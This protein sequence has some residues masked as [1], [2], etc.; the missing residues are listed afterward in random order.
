MV[1]VQADVPGM[2][3]RGVVD[4]VK[5]SYRPDI[6]GLRA[7]SILLV[8]VF[9]AG[10]SG[11]S[12]G[13]VGVDVFFVISGF[14]ITKLVLAEI[15]EGHFSLI[16][17]YRRRMRRL[18]P[19][20][21]V[22]LLAAI[23]A[24]FVTMTPWQYK[25]FLQTLALALVFGTNFHF[26]AKGGY[27]DDPIAAQPLL[28]TWSLAIEEQFYVVWPLILLAI[29][30]WAPRHVALTLAAGT[31]AMFLVGLLAVHFDEFRAFFLPTSRA[32]QLML[33][34]TLGAGIA[35]PKTSAT[36]D[37][38]SCAGLLLIAT[39]AGLFS[40]QTLY[41][42]AASIVPPA[43]AALLI[44]S[45]TAKL[46]AVGRVLSIKPAIALG[47]ISYGLYLWHWPIFVFFKIATMREPTWL[48]TTALIGLST[49]LA[50]I[51]FRYI[52]TPVRRGRLIPKTMTFHAGGLVFV[53]LMAF[54]LAGIRFEGYESRHSALLKPLLTA[55]GERLPEIARCSLSVR[56]TDTRDTLCAISIHASPATSVLIWGDSHAN[57]I[58][59][60]FMEVAK[61]KPAT[62]FLA[63]KAECP[64]LLDV[65]RK[66]K[67]RDR[68]LACLDRNATVLDRARA[69]GVTD[70]V[71]AGRWNN[72]VGGVPRYGSEMSSPQ[73]HL[74]NGRQTSYSLELD[75][76]LVV[77]GLRQ[78]VARIAAA[79]MR[80]WIVE[81]VPYA[82]APV[83]DLLARALINGLPLDTAGSFSTELHERRAGGMRALLGELKTEHAF[84]VLDLSKG[85]C[86][87]SLCR[88]VGNGV[89]LYRDHNHLT[90]F[91]AR[92]LAGIVTP[93]FER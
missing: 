54:A 17:F 68:L 52:E 78:T 61:S 44:W 3:H 39:A 75:R 40:S 22:V 11:L 4:A 60:A 92:G 29:V 76:Q 90:V 2:A 58:A 79:G 56:D 46:S 6:D 26:A 66:F 23:V 41:P 12:G 80:V 9:H 7:L 72:Y 51:C 33:G 32:W 37:V 81:E 73:L 50:A 71:L 35:G 86:D 5:P 1:L 83:I 57:A 21:I 36:A 43:G 38:S 19:T 59:P 93:V 42:G 28:H 45:S 69:S 14:L 49:G 13:F 62:I 67:S 63:S 65:S 31:V 10:Y 88:V 20:L 55:S 24:G 77:A 74:S 47:L 82:G 91:A 89:A 8:V 16:E 25:T 34:A 18:M 15:I 84:G 70:V 27:F 87:G 48:E 64:P 30:R 53:A 85:L